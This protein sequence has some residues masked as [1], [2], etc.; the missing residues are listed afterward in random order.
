VRDADKLIIYEDPADKLNF[1]EDQWVYTV[2]ENL[3][4]QQEKEKRE[5]EAR[6]LKLKTVQ[7]EQRL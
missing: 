6:Q 2:K 3:R 4:K 1:S 7:E 5:K